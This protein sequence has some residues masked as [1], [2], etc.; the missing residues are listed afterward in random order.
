MSE[1]TKKRAK[2][3]AAVE[4]VVGHSHAM[5]R[6]LQEQGDDIAKLAQWIEEDRDVLRERVGNLFDA[7]TKGTER[8]LSQ[9]QQ[10]ANERLSRAGLALPSHDV[11]ST[12]RKLTPSVIMGGKSKGDI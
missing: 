5:E 9:A 8:M 4:D 7:Y 10:R 12:V 2:L 6:E 11:Q 3:L 1:A